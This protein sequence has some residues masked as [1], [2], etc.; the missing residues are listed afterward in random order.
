[1]KAIVHETAKATVHEMANG[2]VHEMANKTVHEMA[3]GATAK[4]RGA[5]DGKSEGARDGN[6]NGET[7]VKGTVKVKV[8]DRG[9]VH[10]G[11]VKDGVS[12]ALLCATD[13]PTIIISCLSPSLILKKSTYLAHF[14]KLGLPDQSNKKRSRKPRELSN[15]FL[16]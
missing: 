15:T 16:I 7:T 13:P 10:K 4:V 1:M 14:P 9:R 5:Q 8:Q 2:T 6:N 3:K 11:T 12:L